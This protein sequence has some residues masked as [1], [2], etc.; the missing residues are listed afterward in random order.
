[1]TAHINHDFSNIFCRKCLVL[2]D[3][4][5][6]IYRPTGSKLRGWGERVISTRM[7]TIREMNRLSV[8]WYLSKTMDACHLSNGMVSETMWFLDFVMT[9]EVKT[10]VFL[11]RALMIIN[12][13]RILDQDQI[14]SQ[15]TRHSYLFELHSIHIWNTR[16]HDNQREHVIDG[17]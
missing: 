10:E 12:Q 7:S 6:V 9:H 17:I 11:S 14:W 16:R 1:M 8:Q 2:L 4:H 3:T 13:Q 5:K 15:A